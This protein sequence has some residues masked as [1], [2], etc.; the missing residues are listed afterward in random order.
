MKTSSDLLETMGAKTQSTPEQPAQTEPVV[1]AVETVEKKEESSTPVADPSTWTL[2]SA[3][4]E[5]KKVREEAKALRLKSQEQVE[6]VKAQFMEQIE[7]FKEENAEALDAKRQLL[8]LKSKEEDKKRSLDE[9]LA[10]R[11]AALTQVEREKA[12]L[13]EQLQ[14][15]LNLMKEKLSTY[16]VEREA[17]MSVYKERISEELNNIPEK[18]RKFADSLV[19]GYTDPREGWTALSEAKMSGMFIDKTVVVSHATPGASEGARTTGEA[20]TAAKRAQYDKMT[21]QAKIRAGLQQFDPQNLP[22][23]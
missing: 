10:H 22:K 21:A 1:K 15:E 11:E 2:D 13:K 12:L 6:A 9:R 16:E 23:I 3:L 5:V 14:N 20:Q 18:Y 19:R 8:E 17:Q 7:K 4:L